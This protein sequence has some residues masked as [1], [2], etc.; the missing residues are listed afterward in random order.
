VV[1]E[2]RLQFEVPDDPEVSEKL[3]GEHVAVNPVAGE[4]VLDTVRVPVKPF[5]LVSVIADAPVEPTWNVTTVG[6]ATT[7]K[8]GGAITLIAIEIVCVSEPLVPV[9]VT[10]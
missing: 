2:L 10:V 6:F 7:L 9:I 1:E 4:M 5:R 3:V 8:S